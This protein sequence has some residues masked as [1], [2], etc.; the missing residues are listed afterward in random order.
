MKR[1]LTALL[2]ALVAALGGPGIASTAQAAATPASTAP[3]RLM[4]LGDSITWGYGSSTGNGYRAALYDGL[5]ADGHPLDFVGSLRGGT[6]SDPDNEG[7]SGY[8]IDQVAALTDAVLAQYQP[9]VVTLEIGTNDLNGNY[10]V[11]TAT[12]RLKAMVDQITR[13]VPS[14]TVLVASLVVSTSSTEEQYRGA[15]NAAIPGIVQSEQAAGRHVGYVDMSAVTTADLSDY[16]HPNDR[17]YQKMADAFRQ[18]VR[19]ADSAGWLGGSVSASG[20]VRSGIAGK[21]LDVRNGSNADG[22]A[23]QIYACNNA[24]AQNW[25]AY[26]DGTLRAVGKCLDATGRRTANGTQIEIWTCNGGANQVWQAVN[27]AY[28]NPVSGRCLDDPN[29][30]TTDGTQLQLWDCNGQANQK[31]TAVVPG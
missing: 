14:A 4:P 19:A 2:L 21:C 30:S 29:S 25:T 27:G 9:N 15:Y 8:R 6:M 18:G 3:V 1:P 17:G 7:H 12:A 31:W 23:A 22:T 24:A 5:A 26:P 20:P 16:L 10:Q 11:A 13:D 28:V